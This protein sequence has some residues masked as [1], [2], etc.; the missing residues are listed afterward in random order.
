MI[1]GISFDVEDWFQ[2]ENLKAAIPRES[3][4]MQPIRVVKSTQKILEIL[5]SSETRA[6]FFFLGWIAERC[7]ELV[8]E[9]AAAGHEI[10]CHGY[11]HELIYDISPDHFR[12]DIRR[13]KALLEDISGRE[14]IGYR[15]PSFSITER[16]VWAV[17]E[18]KEAGFVYDSSIFPTSLHDR[19]GFSGVATT[20]FQWPCGLSEIPLAVLEI[21]KVRLPAAGGGYFRLFPYAYFKYA[22]RALNSAGRAFTFYMHPWEFDPEQPRVKVKASYYFRHY[23][24][25]SR[26]EAR[27]RR[28]VGDFE[29]ASLGFANG[30]TAQ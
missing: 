21:G 30:F 13:S 11:D 25:L 1:N 28:L 16:S 24:N 18:L 15:A 4:E 22:L 7:P 26:T 29:F 10:A 3:W 20:P 27:L 14:V 2:V 23:C 5:H 9:V 6:T 8:R 19:Y 17:E 12:N